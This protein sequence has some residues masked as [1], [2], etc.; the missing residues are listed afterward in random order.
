MAAVVC[1]PAPEV[2]H[3]HHH[4]CQAQ[5]PKGTH[6]RQLQGIGMGHKWL[7]L[8]GSHQVPFCHARGTVPAME[9]LCRYS[10]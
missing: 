7:P 8:Q 6:L 4:A 1:L 5:P 9:L 3:Q 2:H 10:W